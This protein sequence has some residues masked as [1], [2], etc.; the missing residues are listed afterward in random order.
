MNTTAPDRLALAAIQDPTIRAAIQN[1]IEAHLAAWPAHRLA[2]AYL[3][4]RETFAGF[5]YAAEFAAAD[6]RIAA[7]NDDL[8][9][10]MDRFR[11]ALEARVN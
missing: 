2:D 11:L 1:V 10:A 6:S 3:E 9:L 5:P 8:F 7:A 4:A